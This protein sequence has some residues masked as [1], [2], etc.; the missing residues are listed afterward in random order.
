MPNFNIHNL[1][2]Q[3]INFTSPPKD[4]PCCN[5]HMRFTTPLLLASNV[6]NIHLPP[7]K[8]FGI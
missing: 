4:R 8:G 7:T 3:T 6:E 1:K 2:I 5:Q